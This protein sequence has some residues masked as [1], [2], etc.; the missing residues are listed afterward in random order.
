[1]IEE[2]ATRW[3]TGV[4]VQ[5]LQERRYFWCPNLHEDLTC[6]MHV[7]LSTQLGHWCQGRRRSDTE[8]WHWKRTLGRMKEKHSRTAYWE[9][10]PSPR[11]LLRYSHDGS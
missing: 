8:A 4:V 2:S 3:L 7:S 11:D 1:M 10:D 6:W 9:E 5:A